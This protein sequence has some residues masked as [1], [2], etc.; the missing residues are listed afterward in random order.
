MHKVHANNNVQAEEHGFEPRWLAWTQARP[1]WTLLFIL[2]RHHS[3]IV[4]LKLLETA[5]QPACCL[6]L[7]SNHSQAVRSQSG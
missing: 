3:G 2:L 1:H 7:G 4:I 6:Y 5:Q